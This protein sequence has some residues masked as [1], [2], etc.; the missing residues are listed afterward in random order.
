M[1]LN[2]E[3]I[4]L[5]LFR[6]KEGLLEAEEIAE[7][8]EAF[9]THPEWKEMADAY[10]PDFKLPAGATIPYANYE[11]LRDGGA[12]VNKSYRK[13]SLREEQPYSRRKLPVWIVFAAAACLLLFVTTVVRLVDNNSNMKKGPILAG[14][15]DKDTAN[16]VVVTLDTIEEESTTDVRHIAESTINT[17]VDEEE[18]LYAEVNHSEE[19]PVEMQ[20][21]AVDTNRGKYD[22]DEPTLREVNDPMDQEILYATG[23]IERGALSTSEEPATRREQLRNLA[24]RATSLA[25]S[26]IVTHKQRRTAIK[27]TIEDRIEN[28]E[29]INN[30]IATLE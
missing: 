15:M 27:E 3:N 1:K 4:E 6:Y 25:A 30:F 20:A 17:I 14:K 13:I 19:S 23:I 26:T 2:E 24:R 9:E 8:E 21:I 12:R 18:P 7:V 11:S 28:N 10:D 5:Y 29:L 16:N 22:L